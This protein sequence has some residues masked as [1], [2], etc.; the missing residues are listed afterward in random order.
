[1]NDQILTAHDRLTL[2]VQTLEEH[3]ESWRRAF[4]DYGRHRRDCLIL[5]KKRS[6]AACACSCG[7]DPIAFTA[8][9]KKVLKA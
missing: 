9:A 1:M 8:G 5:A 4:L 3:L 6:P 2:R 7:F